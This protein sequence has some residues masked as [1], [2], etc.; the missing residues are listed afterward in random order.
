MD[1]GKCHVR[2]QSPLS[3]RTLL[4]L[5]VYNTV[6]RYNQPYYTGD[7]SIVEPALIL[8]G[9]LFALI[10]ILIIYKW[11]LS[12]RLGVLLLILQAAMNS[13]E[14]ILVIVARECLVSPCATACACFR[15]AGRLLGLERCRRVPTLFRST[16]LSEGIDYSISNTV[17]RRAF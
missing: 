8:F 1:A 4:I 13:T 5:L 2:S 7:T 12:G 14:P 10:L 16:V 17:L 3:T 15:P 9:Y 11:Q 6:F